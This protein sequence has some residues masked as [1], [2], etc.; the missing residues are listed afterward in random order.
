MYMCVYVC[1]YIYYVYLYMDKVLWG[2]FRVG[3]AIT[4]V[5]YLATSLTVYVLTH[6]VLPHRL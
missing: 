5:T 2:A 1:V 3:L 4:A 6:L